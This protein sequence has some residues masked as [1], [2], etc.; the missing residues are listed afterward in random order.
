MKVLIIGGTGIISTSV[1]D[2]CIRQG[3][4]VSMLNRG[5]NTRFINPKATHIKCNVYNAEDVKAKLEGK[6][7]DAVIDFL[8]RTKAEIE[9]SMSLFSKVADQYVFISSAQAYNTSIEGILR[10]DSE[11]SQPQWAYSVNKVICEKYVVQKC[12]ELNQ[13]YTII[14]PGVNYGNTRIPYGMFPFIGSHWTM[15]ARIK[16]DKPI[17]TWNNGQNKLNLTRVE[18]FASGAVGLIGNPKAYNEIFNVVGDYVY[19]WHEVLEV[20]GKLIN[21]KVRT[22]DMPVEFYAN[23]LDGDTRE[24]LIGGRANDMVCSNEKL[25][26]VVPNY[27]TKY[28]LEKGLE[29]TLNFYRENDY[30]MGFDYNWEGVT[31]RV[32]KKYLKSTGKD[33][34]QNLHFINYENRGDK[35]KN[36]RIY[37]D[38]LNKFD[39]NAGLLN[40]FYSKIRI[41]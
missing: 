7:Y 26:S 1:V 16:A 12:K 29:L 38:A 14:R 20:L 22:I 28:T 40:K 27:K 35:A 8:V 25:K 34:I 32:I 39:K 41:L 3:Y 10:E 6:Y 13:N 37:K 33:S 9:Y 15:V 23:E 2:E 5:N 4:D 17:I 18:D 11:L 24:G 36:Y 19:T 21:H 30:Y 31:D